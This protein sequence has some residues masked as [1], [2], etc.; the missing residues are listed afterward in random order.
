MHKYSLVA[1]TYQGAS[2]TMLGDNKTE[3]AKRFKD[4]YDTYGF[5]IHIINNKTESR[6]VIKATYR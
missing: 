2:I 4:T 1:Q 6:Q 5:R 3:L